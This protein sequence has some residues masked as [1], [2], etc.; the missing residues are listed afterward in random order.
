[1]M[2][3]TKVVDDL[4][5]L[6]GLEKPVL[7]PVF[8]TDVVANAINGALQEIYRL[9]GEFFRYTNQVDLVYGGGS[10]PLSM[11]TMS[12]H[13]STKIIEIVAPDGVT[14]LRPLNRRQELDHYVQTYNPAAA[15]GSPEAFWVE[16]TYSS[17]PGAMIHIAPPALSSVAIT[18]KATTTFELPRLDPAVIVAY[19]EAS[20]GDGGTSLNSVELPIPLDWIETYL[21]PL[22]RKQASRSHYWIMKEEQAGYEADYQAA[23]EELKALNPKPKSDSSTQSDPN[24]GH[25]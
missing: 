14:R 7:A 9:V 22:A 5:R 11:V 20:G 21:M 13:E 10:H 4:Y 17:T 23:V 24:Q 25:A 19:T 12:I 2:P 3:L 6:L 15:A 18:L 8:V 16:R 1:M